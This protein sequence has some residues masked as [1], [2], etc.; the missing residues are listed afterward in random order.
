[1]PSKR[2]RRRSSRVFRSVSLHSS[3]TVLFCLEEITAA[4]LADSVTEVGGWAFYGCRGL[5]LLD[6]G[7]GLKT[8]DDS[9]FEECQ[10]LKS[11]RLP[12]GLQTLGD[13]AFFH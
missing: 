13:Q 4:T 1:M 5:T 2:K 7:D 11:V 12:E 6:L 8:I 10:S 9:A 3:T